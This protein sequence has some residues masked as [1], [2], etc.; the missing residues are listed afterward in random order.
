M[1]FSGVNRLEELWPF[2]SY[3]MLA[4]GWASSSRR[5]RG[6]FGLNPSPFPYRYCPPPLLYHSMPAACMAAFPFKSLSCY[7]ARKSL[8][9]GWFWFL[10]PRRR[11]LSASLL[12][13]KSS[14]AD[15][16]ACMRAAFSVPA[17]GD[18]GVVYMRTSRQHGE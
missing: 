15:H 14:P 11:T 10:C 9:G 7:S 12:Y 18:D 8:A 2:S 1:L 3:T 16:H 4:H 5:A 17:G 6:A 13:H